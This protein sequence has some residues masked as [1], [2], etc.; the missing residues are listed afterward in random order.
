LDSKE[1]Y[2][3]LRKEGVLVR[4]F[5]YPIHQMSM[6][7]DYVFNGKVVID[8]WEKGICLPGSVNISEEELIYVIKAINRNYE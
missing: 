5:F 2:K 4:P 7:K 8:L 3:R 6:Y 1:L